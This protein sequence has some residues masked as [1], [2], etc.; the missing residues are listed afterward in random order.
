MMTTLQRT[1]QGWFDEGVATDIVDHENP[2]RFVWPWAV[3][4]VINDTIEY[5]QSTAVWEGGVVLQTSRDL[6]IDS[7]ICVRRSRKNG[8]P[9]VGLRV[10][11]STRKE[12]GKF[13]VD[14][15]L[16]G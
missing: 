13:I 8:E 9:W 15:V 14:A 16:D 2:D 5:A 1:A 11:A 10:E 7:A 6:P 4:I 3:E 12:D